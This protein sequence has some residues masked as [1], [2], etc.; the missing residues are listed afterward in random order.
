M[1]GAEPPRPDVRAIG[2][3]L[4]DASLPKSAWNH[5]A[6]LAAAVYLL[7]VRGDL[8]AH[9]VMP[10][11]IRRLNE[12]HGVANSDTSGYHETL[13][14][15]FLGVIA[16]LLLSLPPGTPPDAAFAALLR[17]PIAERDFPLRFYSR[18]LLMSSRARREWVPPDRAPL[19]WAA[20]D[21]SS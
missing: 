17:T 3:G 4:L 8:D 1:S 13:T 18:E 5:H 16:D 11:L 19:P 10:G 6:H 12:A 20:A 14:R 9:A 2:E 7:A 21:D 15:V